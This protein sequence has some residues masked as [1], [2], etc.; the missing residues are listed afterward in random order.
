MAA[1]A[2][3]SHATVHRIWKKNDL[4]P[5]LTKTFKVSNDP[6]FVSKFWDIIGL[7]LNPPE[8]AL[9]LCCDEKSQCQALERTQPSLPLGMDGYITTVTHDY[10]RHGTITLF[11]ALCYL[12]GKIISRTE[13]NHSHVEWLR[14]LKQIKR[15]TDDKIEI[16][17]IADNYSTHKHERV[18]A[19]FERNPRFKLHFTPTGSSWMNLVERFFRDISEECIRHGSFSSVQDLVNDITDYLTT[20]NLRPRKYRWKAEGQKILEKINRAREKLGKC[21]Y[22]T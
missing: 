5:H 12:D 3:V 1:H 10:R 6:Q 22:S 14:F 4:K 19:W 8:K 13:D 9:V 15:E 7:Y 11:A 20:W 17:I 2:G 21:G 16:H 18:R